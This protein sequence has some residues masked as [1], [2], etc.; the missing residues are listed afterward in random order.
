[1]KKKNENVV[2]KIISAIF[3]LAGVIIIIR[4]GFSDG[5]LAL[6]VGELIDINSRLE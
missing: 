2:V 6:I 5:C 1:M 4:G 3:T